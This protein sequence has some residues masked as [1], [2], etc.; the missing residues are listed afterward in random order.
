VLYRTDTT[1]PVVK[2]QVVPF[3]IIM[4]NRSTVF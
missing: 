4:G 2:G 1:P 3:P